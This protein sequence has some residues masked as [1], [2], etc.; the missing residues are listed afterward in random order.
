MILASV[1]MVNPLNPSSMTQVTQWS[2]MLPLL[3]VDSNGRCELQKKLERETK[4][5]TD[6]NAGSVLLNVTV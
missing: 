2:S 5:E 4:T 6:L 1:A 3:H